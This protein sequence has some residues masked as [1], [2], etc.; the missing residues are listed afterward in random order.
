MY[1]CMSCKSVFEEPRRVQ[2]TDFYGRPEDRPY[3]ECPDS[4]CR[5]DY[6]EEVK[7][8]EYCGEYY[9]DDEEGFDGCCN[10]CEARGMK[11]L[12]QQSG[13]EAEIIRNLISC[14]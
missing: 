5:G 13:Q 4:N 8:C 2:V 11:W 12:G 9:T 7:Q 1:K 6:I 10:D 3:D 14:F